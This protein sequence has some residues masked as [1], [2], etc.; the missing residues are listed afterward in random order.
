[1][2]GNKSAVDPR[3]AFLLYLDMGEERSVNGVFNL[4]KSQGRKI[5]RQTVINWHRDDEWDK[6]IPEVMAGRE[7]E[8]EAVQIAQVA[9]DV[10]EKA[11]APA[12]DQT[13]ELLLV[14]VDDFTQAESF[15]AAS[16]KVNG[17][18][19]GMAQTALQMIGSLERFVEPAQLVSIINATRD[20]TKAAADAHRALNPA[21]V[22]GK[23]GADGPDLRP[24][25]VL[26]PPGRAM[27]PD[28]DALIEGT[29][30]PPRMRK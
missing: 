3:E 30:N 18:V 26:L 23:A 17:L 1:M 12:N 28:I 8:A 5:G 27:P 4:L 22:K 6:R 9:R 25:E 10:L 24:G 15:E 14:A 11:G 19:A 29:R 16:M 13:R 2:A 21:P 7:L 20:L